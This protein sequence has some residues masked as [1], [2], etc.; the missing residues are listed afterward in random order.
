MSSM[1][2]FL[3]AYTVTPLL[4]EH[5]QMV[6]KFLACLIQEKT[7]HEVLDNFFENTYQF[8]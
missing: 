3:N 5:A 4:S 2:Y 7:Q 1:K 6:L 8:F